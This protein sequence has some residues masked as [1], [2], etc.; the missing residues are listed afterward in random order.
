M[1]VF[2]RLCETLPAKGTSHSR[3]RLILPPVMAVEYNRIAIFG[4]LMATKGSGIDD[5]PAHGWDL[6]KWKWVAEPPVGLAAA[7]Y[8]VLFITFL[9]IAG[10]GIVALWQLLAPIW[11][12]A[13]PAPSSAGADLGAELRGRLLIIGAVL[14]TPFLIWRLIVGHWAARA[15]QAQARI[16]Q[17]QAKI[18]QE[19]ARNTLFTKAIEQLGTTRDAKRT[20]PALDVNGIAEGFHDEINTV[21]NIEVRLGAI[22]ALEK[23]ARDDLDMH[24]PIMETLCAYIRENAGP[25]VLVPSNIVSALVEP[26]SGRSKEEG[27]AVFS[28]REQ[29]APLSVDIQAALSVIG[30]RSPAQLE[31]ELARHTETGAIDTGAWR[32]DLRNCSLIK[33]NLA[34][35]DLAYAN[36][37]GSAFYGASLYGTR[38]EGARLFKANLQDVNLSH[39]HMH[40]AWLGLA[41]LEGASLGSAFL[42][43]VSLNE[44]RLSGATLGGAVLTDCRLDGADLRNA[45]G[46][47]A[48]ALSGAWGDTATRLPSNCARPENAQWVT[49]A[50]GSEEWRDH[51]SNWARRRQFWLAEEAKRPGVKPERR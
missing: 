26:P 5:G 7:L 48:N 24:W 10:S 12:S 39:A 29:L 2:K 13:L 33:A 49:A 9:L 18:A 45:Q 3:A 31:Y 23:L 38:L 46:V 44:A 15:A 17:E 28:Y 35:L 41:S 11:I 6:F 36:F 22:Y 34:G 51:Y 4:G 16:A 40:G 19:T 50:L 20:L 8:G 27:E 37:D 1:L 14:S 21:P 30:R 25:P 47:T 43:G 32:L 42:Q